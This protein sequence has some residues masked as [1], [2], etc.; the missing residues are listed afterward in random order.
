VRLRKSDADATNATAEGVYRR[1][2]YQCIAA[3]R[4]LAFA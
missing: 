1:L 4:Q 2:G 3:S